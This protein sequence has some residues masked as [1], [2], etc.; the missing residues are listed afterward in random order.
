MPM[1]GAVT[2]V[3]CLPVRNSV[4][5]PTRSVQLGPCTVPGTSAGPDPVIVCLMD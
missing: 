1:I 2:V 5:G 4:A 3:T